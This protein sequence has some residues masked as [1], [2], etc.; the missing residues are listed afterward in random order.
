MIWLSS[1]Q[2]PHHMCLSTTCCQ[3]ELSE[4]LDLS[5]SICLASAKQP[6]TYL[7]DHQPHNWQDRSQQLEKGASSSHS[8]NEIDFE[9]QPNS[10][11]K[12][13]HLNIQISCVCPDDHA[14]LHA[15]DKTEQV[16]SKTFRSSIPAEKNKVHRTPARSKAC[17]WRFFGSQALRRKSAQRCLSSR[18]QN[19]VRQ[20]FARVIRASA[21]Y[22]ST[23]HPPPDFSCGGVAAGAGLGGAEPPAPPPPAPPAP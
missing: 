23:Q 10:T 14:L 15:L 16:L 9:V 13:F 5:D 7:A 21:P 18:A 3:D 6:Q 17:A 1:H 4:E 2:P 20:A 8:E 11:R 22:C 12:R 19:A